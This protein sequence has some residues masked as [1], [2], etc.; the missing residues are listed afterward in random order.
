MI[1][2]LFWENQPGSSVGKIKGVYKINTV[3]GLLS[4]YRRVLMTDWTTVVMGE[5]EKSGPHKRDLGS[6]IHRGWHLIG[7]R[8]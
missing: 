5:T 7:Y 3:R 2:F 1:R 4:Q 8:E 6:M